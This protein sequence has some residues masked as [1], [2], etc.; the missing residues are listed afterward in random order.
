MPSASMTINPWLVSGAALSAVAAL[1]HVAIIIGGGD[2]YRFF[3]AGEAMA[4]MAEAGRLYPAL[5]TAGIAALLLVW[6]FYALAGAGCPTI[7]RL[8]WT[9]AALCAITTIYL[10][11]GLAPLPLCLLAP[12]RLTPFLLWSSLICSGYGLVHLIG[13]IQVWRRL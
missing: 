13:L 6:S 3:G 12:A 1:L 5:L 9:K 7:P 11:R 8:P 2:W 10:V 4:Q